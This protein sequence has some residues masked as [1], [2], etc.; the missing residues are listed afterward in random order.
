MEFEKML[1]GELYRPSAPDLVAARHRAKRLCHLYNAG[2]AD[3]D[4]KILEE[5]F[6]MPTDAHL[7]P[8]FFCDYGKQI[9]LGRGV[10]ANHNLVILD[11]ARVE[12]GDGVLFGPNVVVSTAG[13]PTD[14]VQR[15][16]GLEFARPIVIGN[17]AWIGANVSI[18][19]GVTIGADAVIGAGSVVTR[20]VP[21]GATA[22]GVPARP[23]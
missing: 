18:M 15:K 17:N 22:F 8:P 6:G 14:P 7:E 5:L 1:A 3:R 11:C 23:R 4:W 9:L 16:A 21:A 10:Y 2:G 20:D 12:I 19:P 13:H